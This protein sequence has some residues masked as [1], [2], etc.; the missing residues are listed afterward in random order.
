MGVGNDLLDALGL[1]GVPYFDNKRDDDCVD[2]LS[3]R[4]TVALLVLFA[5]FALLK[6]FVGHPVNCWT[7][8]HFSKDSHEPYTNR[9]L[10]I[11]TPCYS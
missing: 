9:S 4:W 7:P 6:Q 10:L 3:H 2:R 8:K 11:E 1:K 5:S